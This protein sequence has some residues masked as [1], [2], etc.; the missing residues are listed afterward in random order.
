[1][2]NGKISKVLARPTEI[3][4][5]VICQVSK[6]KITNERVPQIQSGTTKPY[7]LKVFFATE[8]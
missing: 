2:P 4:K 3:E 8:L 5:I 6:E 7:F 1:M